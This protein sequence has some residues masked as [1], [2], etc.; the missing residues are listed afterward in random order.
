MLASI[1][2][3]GERARHNRWWITVTWLA[4]AATLGGAV[5]AGLVAMAGQLVIG[6]P[7]R[8][9]YW[10]LAALACL[11]AALVDAV[12]WVLPPHRQ[13]DEGW[14]TAYRRW[15]YACGFGLQLGAGV[16]TV[17]TSAAVPL[18]FFLAF[19]GADPV[20]GAFTGAAFGLARSL[21]VAGLAGIDT[22]IA[23]RRRHQ[24]LASAAP[25][26][27]WAAVGALVL[28]AAAL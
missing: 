10:W 25:V 2:P 9:S 12:G 4:A 19:L 17:I 22:P 8:H 6:R 3:F 14:L 23:L 13:V 5:L 11:A 18:L 27:R 21:P 20:L 28:A 16:M 24:R 26:A 1:S 15:V 7:A